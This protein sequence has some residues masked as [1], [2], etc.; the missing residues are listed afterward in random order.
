MKVSKKML[1]MKNFVQ[2]IIVSILLVG[3]S[4]KTLTFQNPV[5]NMAAPDPTIVRGSDGNFYM[6]TT[7][8]INPDTV[9]PTFMGIPFLIGRIISNKKEEIVKSLNEKVE[10]FR[11]KIK[12][13]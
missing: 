5:W 7:Q 13:L 9:I 1:K 10:S 6:Y 2:I 3:C 12:N 8:G 4:Q 11:L